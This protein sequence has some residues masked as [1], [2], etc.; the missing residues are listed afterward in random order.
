MIP[1]LLC[2][3][4]LWLSLHELI[5]V[6]KRESRL[7]PGLCFFSLL[8]SGVSVLQRDSLTHLASGHRRVARLPERHDALQGSA[9][10]N[11]AP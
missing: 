11:L 6:V 7:G 4:G 3:K 2:V 5:C 1:T 10:I 9:K 8:K